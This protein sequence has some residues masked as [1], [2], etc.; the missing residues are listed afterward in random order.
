ML[1][2]LSDIKN[3]KLLGRFSTSPP[4]QGGIPFHSIYVGM[5]DRGFVVGNPEALNPDC[6]EDYLPI[7]VIDVRNEEYPIGIAQFPRPKPPADAPYNDFCQKR[8]RFGAHNPIELKAPGR[9]SPTFAAVAQFNAGLR[10]Y[11]L[12]EPTRPEETAY[13]IPPQGGVITDPSSFNRTVEC[14][15][16]EWDRKV[17]YI[18]TTTG[19]YALATPA[20]GKPILDPMPVS[21][22]SLP[23]LN[24]GAPS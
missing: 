12:T 1:H 23:G 13:F 7:W 10:C 5:L 11:D 6:N 17:M 4:Y 3:P 18:T 21:E 16:V 24:A 20:L 22:W 14:V 15:F 2:D 19:L 9:I 8:G